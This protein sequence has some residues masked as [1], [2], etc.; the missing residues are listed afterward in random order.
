LDTAKVDTTINNCLR[1]ISGAIKSTPV[2][3]LPVLTN[4]MPSDI[5]RNGALT[6]E[7]R[8]IFDN[9]ELPIH[10]DLNS[11]IG[12]TPRLKSRKPFWLKIEQID[13]RNYDMAEEWKS[14]WNNLELVNSDFIEDPNVMLPGNELPRYTWTQLNRFRTNH[15]RCNAM[16]HRWDPGISPACDCGN[17]L[18]TIHHIVTDCINRKFSGEFVDLINAT[19]NAIEWI[20]NLNIVL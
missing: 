14:Q 13:F 10:E 11:R 20:R 16:L 4:I 9:A 8:K 2:Q 15:G 5:R 3:W 12:I 18:Q 1:L 17:S 19:E 7:A 6:R